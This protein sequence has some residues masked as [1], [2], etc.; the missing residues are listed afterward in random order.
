MARGGEG[1][2]VEFEFRVGGRLSIVG[3]VLRGGWKCSNV[4]TKLLKYEL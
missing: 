3:F 1:S 4:T 2:I